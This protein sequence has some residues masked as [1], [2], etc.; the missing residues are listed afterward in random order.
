METLTR[1]YRKNGQTALQNFKH[2]I[3]RSVVNLS[4][5][6][7]GNER[8]AEKFRRKIDDNFVVISDCVKMR[9]HSPDPNKNVNKLNLT[10][11]SDV[12]GA[13]LWQLLT[14]HTPVMTR[15]KQTNDWRIDLDISRLASTPPPTLPCT[16]HPPPSFYALSPRLPLLDAKELGAV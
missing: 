11:K 7:K 16:S 12:T 14:N 3:P 10:K 2:K 15:Q 13:I 8:I 9:R 1:G 6:C 5:V 4:C